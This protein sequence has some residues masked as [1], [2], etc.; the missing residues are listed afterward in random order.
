MLQLPSFM[1]LSCTLGIWCDTARIS[2][3]VLGAITRDPLTAR[4]EQ[5]PYQLE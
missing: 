1:L 3:A 4:A 5:G 2:D